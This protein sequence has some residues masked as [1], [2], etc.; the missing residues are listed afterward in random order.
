V[1]LIIGGWFYHEGATT[2]VYC[3]EVALSLC[4]GTRV[5]VELT[6]LGGFAKVTVDV[7][8]TF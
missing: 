8:V 6:F 7:A 3:A 5:A 2:A 4:A 1:P